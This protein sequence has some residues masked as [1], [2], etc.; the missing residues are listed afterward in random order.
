MAREEALRREPATT[1]HA[2]PLDR[3]HRVFRA[4]GHVTAGWRQHRAHGGLIEAKGREN[5]GLHVA[6][7]RSTSDASAT[8][9]ALRR[10]ANAAEAVN[11]RATIT[12]SQPGPLIRSPISARNASRSRRRE[13]LRATARPS[14]RGAA[15]ATR[16]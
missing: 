1:D 10:S 6:A 7:T 3:F 8:A 2:V 13:R 5:G 15:T 16:I 14:D 12:M 9:A 4:G 11:G